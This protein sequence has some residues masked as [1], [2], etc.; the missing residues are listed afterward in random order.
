[1]RLLALR[2]LLAS[3]ALAAIAS[4]S[5]AHAQVTGKTPRR[6]TPTPI[7][8]QRPPS[9]S[10]LSVDRIF[11]RGDFASA[12]VPDIHWLRDGASYLAVR[13]S[14]T[15]AG[16]EIV[17]VDVATGATTVLAPASAL[18]DENGQRIEVEDIQLSRDESKALLFHNS[19]RVWRTNT[20]GVYHVLDFATRR[21]TP[22]AVVR[23]QQA[24]ATTRA[25][26]G[27]QNL[28]GKEASFIA[29]PTRS[30]LQMFAK[31]SPDGRSVAFVRDND[32]FVT[33]LAS[34]RET[35]LTSDGSADV[36]NGTSDWVYEEELGLKDAFRWSPDSRRI[37]YWR[38]DQ[39]A[40]PAF[41]IVNETAAQY[42]SVGVL[43]YPK[44]GAPNSRVKVGVVDVA[45]G[46]VRAVLGRRPPR[47]SAG[48]GNDGAAPPRTSATRWLDIG[49][50]TGLYVARMEWVGN[51][52][53]AVQRLPRKQNRLDLLVLSANTG[54]GRTVV[55]DRDSAYV[56]VEGEAVTWIDG[57]RRFLLR[58]D[59]SGWRQ[60]YLYDRA[61]T[62]L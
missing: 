62:L 59:R 13:P 31:F 33:D 26:T 5:V 9:D 24:G 61:G 10:Q 60:L 17:R 41:P 44:A 34:G 8:Q 57:G 6:P 52:S 54:Q 2:S 48:D 28:L 15:G 14:A 4:G 12:P 11:S 39:S 30:G 16:S 46:G 43:R 38:F 36:I 29:P 45:G 1:M 42:P 23:T 50:D 58:S 51:D 35:R 20:R 25:D 55:T 18:V 49:G 3:S 40:V 27:Q 19:V 32:L 21:L 7:P 22:I 37:A 53:L 47:S 56:D